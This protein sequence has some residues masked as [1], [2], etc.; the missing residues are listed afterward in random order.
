MRET[1]GEQAFK[2]S[3][4]PWGTKLSKFETSQSSRKNK[5]TKQN[6]KKQKQKQKQKKKNQLINLT[7]SDQ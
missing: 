3:I 4:N 2:S 7:L 1:A 6:K 5:N